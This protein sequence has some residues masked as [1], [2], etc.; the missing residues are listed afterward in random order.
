METPANM[1]GGNAQIMH[2]E[3]RPAKHM[4]VDA[5]QDKMFFSFGIHRDQECVIDIAVAVFPD[6]GDPSTEFEPLCNR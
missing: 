1:F 2:D 4:C 3:F 6:T 5:L